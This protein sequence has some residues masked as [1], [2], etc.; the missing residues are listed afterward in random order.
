M[1]WFDYADQKI[2]GKEIMIAIP[3]MLIGGGILSMPH[4]M[5]AET[6]GSDGWIPIMIAGMLAIAIAWLVAKLA[7]SYPNQHFL[8]YASAIVTKPVAIVFTFFYGTISLS[9]AAY[10]IRN[11][12]NIAKEYLFDRTPVEVIFLSF[13]LVVVYAV[14]GARIGLFRLNMMFFPFVVVISLALVFFNV[15]WFNLGNLLP[16]FQTSPKDY[17]EGTKAALTSYTGLGILMFYLV[18][19]EQPKKAVKKVTLGVCIPIVTYLILFFTCIAVFGNAATANLLFP[20]LELA[21][22]AELPGGIFERVEIIFYVVWVMT[23]FNTSAMALDVAVLAMQ[24]IFKKTD[25]MKVIL[26]LSPLAYVVGMLPQNY[27]QLQQFGTLISR[28]SVATTLGFAVLLLIIAK[29][30]GVKRDG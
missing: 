19:V 13:L 30:R 21:K 10:V 27:R 5:A 4:D 17:I 16:V 29:V 22:V 1:K 12:S 3:S 24:S 28:T 6:I 14:A 11:I 20:T 25:K 2:G 18:F 26:V 15:K 8:S 9:I 7:T 23:I